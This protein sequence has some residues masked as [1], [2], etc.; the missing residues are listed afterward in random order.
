MFYVRN[1]PCYGVKPAYDMKNHTLYTITN[2]EKEYCLDIYL[3]W[4]DLT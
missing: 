4:C 3:I 1:E 2:A